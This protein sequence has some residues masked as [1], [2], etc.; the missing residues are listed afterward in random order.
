MLRPQMRKSLLDSDILSEITKGINQTVAGHAAKYLGQHTV[1]TFTS[2]SVYETSGA[3]RPNQ[4]PDRQAVFYSLWRSK[5]VADRLRK[6]PIGRLQ[7]PF[8]G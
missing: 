6:R 3:T 8:S 2:V 7:A 5:H 1:L 4:H